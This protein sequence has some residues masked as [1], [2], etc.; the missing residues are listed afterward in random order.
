MKILFYAINGIG[1]GHLNKMILTAKEVRSLRPDW[2]ILFIT[3]SDFTELLAKEKFQYIKLPLNDKDLVVSPL[4][5]MI[6]LED[7]NFFIMRALD[8]YK[9]QVI[10]YDAAFPSDMVRYAAQNGIG[11]VFVMRKDKEEKFLKMLD[12]QILD[13][14]DYACLP[15]SKEEFAELG[16]SK[17]IL[18]L[19]KRKKIELIGPLVRKSEKPAKKDGKFRILVSAGAGGWH[20]TK[21]FLQ[22]AYGACC[23]IIKKG[24]DIECRIITGPYYDGSLTSSSSNIIVEKFSHE[25][26]DI[27]HN[28]TFIISQS[29]Y[30]ICNEIIEAKVPAILY[31]GF[32]LQEDT[33]GRAKRLER[34]GVAIRVKNPSEIM[35]AALSLYSNR[36]QLER[37]KANFRRIT[38]KDGNKKLAGRIVGIAEEMI[39]ADLRSNVRIPKNRKFNSIIFKGNTINEKAFGLIKLAKSR[40]F[41]II[42]LHSNCNR[43]SSREFVRKLIDSGVN[44]FMI[45]FYSTNQKWHNSLIRIKN[46][47]NNMIE[48][49]GILDDEKAHLVANCTVTEKNYAHLYETVRKILALGIFQIQITI[50]SE[51]DLGLGDAMIKLRK[52][53]SMPKY[54]SR[55][56][57]FASTDNSPESVNL[58]KYYREMLN[59]N[60]IMIGNLIEKKKKLIEEN[61]LREIFEEFD[62]KLNHYKGRFTQEYSAS[63]SI[64]ERISEADSKLNK[65][66]RQKKGLWLYLKKHKSQ[67]RRLANEKNA[68]MEKHKKLASK[69]K[70]LRPGINITKKKAASKTAGKYSHL[71]SRQF[72]LEQLYDRFV[73]IPLSKIDASIELLEK[74]F[75][76]KLKLA[77]I[78]SSIRNMERKKEILK[79]DLRSHQNTKIKWL[80]RSIADII[81]E[82]EDLMKKSSVH[83]KFLA[84]DKKIEAYEKIS[85][86]L[87]SRLAP[88]EKSRIGEQK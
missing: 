6:P 55:I 87:R 39:I 79:E 24:K 10:V 45:D 5:K 43:L 62:R 4:Q 44:S 61:K 78:L 48:A 3:N 32:R 54:L 19:I 23:E 11:N 50:K 22:S 51:R 85:S 31:P 16:T 70:R 35:D 27:L 60:A 2:S 30:N 47:F 1:L 33:L 76:E 26:S 88:L 84:I 12:S 58:K 37:M 74:S 67:I 42:Q 86:L 52:L 46:N 53:R 21:N 17:K 63:N 34:N 9:P 40:G 7:Y 71:I 41:R 8:F 14:F 80:K 82:K 25:F 66:L 69:L 75:E 28:S 49:I 83:K 64:E 81:N 65:T 18:R 59:Q 15:Y 56:V 68:I 38:L 13:S 36:K 72:R 73:K 29:G 20:D 77:G 57:Y